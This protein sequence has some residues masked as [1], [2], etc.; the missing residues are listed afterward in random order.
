ML[1]AIPFPDIPR[2]ILIPLPWGGG[3]PLRFYAMAYLVGLIGGWEMI[4]AL[5]R[6][7]HLWPGDRAPMTPKMAEDLLTAIILGVIL[8]GRI[9]YVLFYDL[10]AFIA[11]PIDIVKVWEGGMSFHG[12]FLGVVTAGLWFCRR[13]GIPP[14]QLGD[15]MA[16]V[17]P[18]GLL[19]GR[20][21]NFVNAEL[22]G[23]P[24]TLPWGVIFPGAGG[25]CP[26]DWLHLCARHPT[27]L[28]EAG[29]EGL[30][31]G[32]IMWLIVTRFGALRRPWLVTG[33]FLAGYGLARTLVE[34][35]RMPDDQ[36]LAADPAG[37]VIR[38]GDLGL[39]MGQSLS[40]PMLVIGLVL[41]VA[42]RRRA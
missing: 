23:H 5:M 30:L 8:G 41:I 19:L 33:V 3:L 39:T 38:F 10:D 1:A 4:R 32:L 42:A 9:G 25:N 22:W 31:L 7:P 26:P 37:Y 29:M 24:T 17:A 11:H 27:Q 12:G 2:E 40:L 6:R 14:L 34:V 20:V 21:A 28:Y 15:A 16:L 18:L 36:F 13:H 35:W